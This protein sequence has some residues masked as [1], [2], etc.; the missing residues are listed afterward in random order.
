M[1]KILLLL[2]LIFISSEINSQEK[3]K[4]SV[5]ANAGGGISFSKFSKGSGGLLAN[6]GLSASLNGWMISLKH[7]NET[8]FLS[9][10]N[11][12]ESFKTT[13]ILFG[14]S[15]NLFKEGRPTQLMTNILIGAS[16]ISITERGNLIHRELFGS[17]YAEVHHSAIGLPIEIEMQLRIPKYFGFSFMVYSDINS[18]ENLFGFG[19]N[20]LV[21]KM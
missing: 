15:H 6:F 20:L 3:D 8:E 13:S 9:F 21:G 10:S 19:F 1:K 11:P 17:K 7:R 14:L 16:F 2:F 4:Y 12:N 18:F 5:W